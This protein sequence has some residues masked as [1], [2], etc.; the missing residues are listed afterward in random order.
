MKIQPI[1]TYFLQIS[2]IWNYYSDYILILYLELACLIKYF[3]NI[4]YIIL[5]S[6]SKYISHSVAFVKNK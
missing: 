6:F 4:G 5:I 2:C 1:Y 3:S